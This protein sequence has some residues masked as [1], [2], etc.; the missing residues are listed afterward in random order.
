MFWNTISVKQSELFSYYITVFLIKK[1]T[2][3]KNIIRDQ[4]YGVYMEYFCLTVQSDI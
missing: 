3:K 4:M 1:K 2:K